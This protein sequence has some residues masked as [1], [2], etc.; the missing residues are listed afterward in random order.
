MDSEPHTSRGKRKRSQPTT[1]TSDQK[2]LNPAEIEDF[3]CDILDEDIA[4]ED[5]DDSDNDPDY[6]EQSDH[7]S[8]SEQSDSENNDLAANTS[9]SPA[10]N[11]NLVDGDIPTDNEN[12]QRG[13][14]LYYYGRRT[15]EMMKK[16]VQGF[17][18]KKDYP[19]QAVR[20]RQHNIITQLP[21]LK[22]HAKN[23]GDNPHPI[24][25]W[26]LLFS[27]DMLDEI[28][29]WTNRKIA[30]IRPRYK[31][32]T[33]YI[34]DIDSTELNGFI[35]LLIYSAVFK[36][37]NESVN[38]LFATDGTGRE[39][40]RCTMTKERFLFILHVLR[41]DNP[42]DRDER[43]KDVK[44]AAI[45]KIFYK[46]IENSQ[47]CYTVGP[48]CC[49][50]EM[51]VPFRG[52]CSFKMYLPNKPAKYGLKIQC[53]TDAKTNYLYSA[54]I[55]TGKGSDGR[56]LSEQDQKRL[57]KPTQ[58]VLRLTSPMENSHRNITADNWYSSIELVEE[59]LGKGMTY[60]GTL[61]K[62]KTEIPVCFLPNRSRKENEALYGYTENIT[63]LSY[64]PK[65][66][67]AVILVSSMHHGPGTDETI[68]KPEIIAEYNRTKGGVDTVD[69]MC[70]NYS[71]QR[72]SRRWPMAIFFALINIS[73][74][75][76]SFI[77]Y[78]AYRETPDTNRL[79]FMKVLAKGLVS[80]L[81]Q[82]RLDRGH[83]ITE[84]MKLAI[85]RILQIQDPLPE[86]QT[87]LLEHRKT[88]YICPPRLKRKTRFPCCVCRKPICLSCAQKVCVN[89][90]LDRDQ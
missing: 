4:N 12:L 21:G 15:K 17:R 27:K 69:Q 60:V 77:L 58:A 34:H 29:E 51:L 42:D 68:N 38:N 81:L 70:S 1:T 52:R 56:S 22:T 64:V 90:K 41:F 76:N 25:V 85:K 43:K 55:Y 66:S 65:K 23:L 49:V 28:L 74:G 54:Y 13:R 57:L 87:E 63:L 37:G 84:E 62:N 33:S 40:F 59:L 32:P 73:A 45:S 26:N 83:H 10:D 71:A 9:T 6:L 30:S 2:A 82:R 8:E 18:W 46:F 39:L 3:L 7:A 11:E 75:V 88:C 89:C 36:S 80:P 61:K 44:E 53:L 35:G 20:T 47:L 86:L 19:N 14:H 78:K 5:I 16:N 72:R 31:N 67:K 50:D 24:D 48:S 79:D